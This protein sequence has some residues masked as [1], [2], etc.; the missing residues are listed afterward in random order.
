MQ[1]GNSKGAFFEDLALNYL[2]Q[3]GLTLLARNVSC[4]FGELD[5]VCQQ[6]KQ[7]VFVEV[8]YRQ[9]NSFGGA[10]A[11]VTLSKQQKLRQTAAWFL[12]QQQKQADCRFDVVAISGDSP[13]QIE[14]IKN[15]F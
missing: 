11:A 14:W 12:Q 8:K 5:L 6:Q 13:Y 15:A 2:Q 1:G 7:W 9:N 3:Q 4:R 10:A